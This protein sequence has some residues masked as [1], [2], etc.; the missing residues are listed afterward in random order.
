MK[1]GN[2]SIAE[3]LIEIDLIAVRDYRLLIKQKDTKKILKLI[4]LCCA[5]NFYNE[6]AFL[7]VKTYEE[8]LIDSEKLK[9]ILSSL[10]N[11][12]RFNRSQL[13]QLEKFLETTENQ[14]W[15]Q[16]MWVPSPSF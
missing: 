10:K 15:A 14:N 11:L 9:S 12:H 13:H 1:Y 2:P 16:Y 3:R 4:S 8:G 7:A 6:A 5:Y